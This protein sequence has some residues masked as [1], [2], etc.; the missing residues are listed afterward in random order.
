VG[1]PGGVCEAQENRCYS[2][3]DTAS[4]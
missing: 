3:P 1:S 4:T 2:G